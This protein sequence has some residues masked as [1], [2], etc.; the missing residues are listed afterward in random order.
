MS[1][2]AERLDFGENGQKMTNI[3]R[4]PELTH[5]H[6]FCYYKMSNYAKP[7]YLSKNGLTVQ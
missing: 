4:F 7:A 5:K 1:N 3:A 6:S 2:N